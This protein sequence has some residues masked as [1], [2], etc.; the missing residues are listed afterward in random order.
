MFFHWS[1]LCSVKGL[2]I[3]LQDKDSI[4]KMKYQVEA[5]NSHAALA[6]LSQ[7]EANIPLKETLHIVMDGSTGCTDSKAR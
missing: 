1:I 4:E 2:Q 3:C 7:V 6:K 5:V